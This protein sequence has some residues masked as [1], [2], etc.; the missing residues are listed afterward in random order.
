MKYLLDVNVLLAGI[1]ENHSHHA[2]A[3]AWLEGKNIVL[4][5]LTELGF[6]RISTNT[7]AIN[8]PMDKARELLD[9]FSAERN[10]ERISDD[11]APLDS[12]PKSSD[13]V[14]DQYL[15]NLAQKHGAKLATF[16]GDI[17]HNAVEVVS[18]PERHQAKPVS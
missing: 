18:L 17:K 12:H 6:L 1:W 8:A 15:A 9:K 4:C 14:T 10:A 11:L 3:F 7:K 5:P 2:E 13:E 16:D